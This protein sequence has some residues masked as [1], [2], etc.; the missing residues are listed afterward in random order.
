MFKEAERQNKIVIV[1]SLIIKI[2]LK[3]AHV[4]M[5]RADIYRTRLYS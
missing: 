5:N 4:D 2:E 1:N 3:F